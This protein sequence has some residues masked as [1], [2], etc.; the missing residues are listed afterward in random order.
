MNLSNIHILLDNFY[1]QNHDITQLEL[2][3]LRVGYVIGVKQKADIASGKVRGQYFEGI[4]AN[5]KRNHGIYSITVVKLYKK[6]AV[7]RKL[8]LANGDIESIK[9]IS[10]N[11]ARKAKLFK[12]W[13]SK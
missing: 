4:L 3:E 12:L 8:V 6:D 5:I 10:A 13:K 9:I 2:P 11:R 7:R 1:K